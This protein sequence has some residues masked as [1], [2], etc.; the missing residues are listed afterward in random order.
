[1]GKKKK[2]T[3]C[4]K[5][6]TFSLIVTVICTFLWILLFKANNIIGN[7]T[8]SGQIDEYDYSM[9]PKK[10]NVSILFAGVDKDGLRTDSIIY[11]VNT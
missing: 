4:S 10:E 1:M 8:T 2:K 7:V 9:E 11:D 5:I 3:L 6:T